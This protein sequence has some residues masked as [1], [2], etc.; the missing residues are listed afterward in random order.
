MLTVRWLET[1]EWAEKGG[2]FGGLPE[3]MYVFDM[4]KAL[5]SLPRNGLKSDLLNSKGEKGAIHSLSRLTTQVEK[6]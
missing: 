4:E 6:M 5:G 2:R 3:W 1:V